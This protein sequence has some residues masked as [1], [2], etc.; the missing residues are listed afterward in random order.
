MSFDGLW[1]PEPFAPDYI[2]RAD[3]TAKPDRPKYTDPGHW[4]IKPERHFGKVILPV[5]SD[6]DINFEMV[7]HSSSQ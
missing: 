2:R 6:A 5:F 3:S 4:S 1:I 7:K